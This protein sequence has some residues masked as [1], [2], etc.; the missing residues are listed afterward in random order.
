VG[1]QHL[2]TGSQAP[3]HWVPDTCLCFSLVEHMIHNV[4]ELTEEACLSVLIIVASLILL[5][6]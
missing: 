2:C 1:P 5:D 3:M 4:L 6:T